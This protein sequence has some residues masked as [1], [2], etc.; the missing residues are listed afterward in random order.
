MRAGWGQFESMA[1]GFAVAMTFEAKSNVRI[2]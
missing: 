2:P 1:A